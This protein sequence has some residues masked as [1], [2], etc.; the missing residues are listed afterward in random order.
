MSGDSRKC[1]AETRLRSG[2]SCLIQ[3]LVGDDKHGDDAVE[4]DLMSNTRKQV[5][6]SFRSR[7]TCPYPI[8]KSRLPHSWSWRRDDGDSCGCRRIKKRRLIPTLI[9]DAMHIAFDFRLVLYN[10][11]Y[12][13]LLC[14]SPWPRRRSMPW[15][16]QSRRLH[17]TRRRLCQPKAPRSPVANFT[18]KHQPTRRWKPNSSRSPS[19]RSSSPPNLK[20]SSKYAD[21]MVIF[22]SMGGMLICLSDSLISGRQPHN[23]TGFGSSPPQPASRPWSPP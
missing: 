4:S 19:L 9:Y 15:Q 3:F 13:I 14:D 12:S 6:I 18:M 23:A 1:C 20:N 16:Q 8:I 2:H 5:R 22:V 7:E 11:R 21:V 10:H 17:F